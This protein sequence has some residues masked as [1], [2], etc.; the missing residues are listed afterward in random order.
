MASRADELLAQGSRAAATELYVQAAE[1]AP[2][3][4][5][6]TFW[7]GLGVAADDMDRGAELVRGAVARKREWLTLLE[8]LPADLEPMAEPLRAALRDA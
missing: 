5:E 8:R 1:L 4:D 6:L 3:A 7:A 2:E